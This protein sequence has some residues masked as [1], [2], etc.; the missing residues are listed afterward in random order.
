MHASILLGRFNL[1][2]WVKVHSLAELGLV[3]KGR[4]VI[5]KRNPVGGFG[6][7]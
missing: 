5:A 2:G 6:E 1:V 3:M 7:E 4:L